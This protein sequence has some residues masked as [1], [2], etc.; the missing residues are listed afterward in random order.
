MPPHARMSLAQQLLLRALIAWFWEQPYRRP[1][2]RWGTDA[3]RPVHAAALCLA[4][5]RA[6]I[7]ADLRARR[8][9]R[10]SPTGSRPTSSSASRSTG[11]SAYRGVELELRQALEP[12]HVLGEEGAIGGTVRYVDCSLERLQ[13][14]SPDDSASATR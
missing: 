13:V 14:R 4:G 9:C 12:W 3:A 5:L 10:S 6:T 7:L 2:V 1:L 8:A 11:Q